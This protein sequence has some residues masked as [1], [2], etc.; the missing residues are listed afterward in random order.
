MVTPTAP[1]LSVCSREPIHIPGSVQ[2]H[3]VLLSIRPRDRVVLQVSANAAS[4]LGAAPDALLGNPLPPALEPALRELALP[5]LVDLPGGRCA[6]AARSSGNRLL[7]EVE[8]VRQTREEAAGTFAALQAALE[9][10][11]RA[12]GDELLQRV[13]EEFQRLTGFERVMVYRFDRDWHGE[14][15]A[16]C[17]DAGF[18]SFLGLHYPA[19]DI[20]AQARALYTRGWLRL[21]PDARATPSPLVPLLDPETAQPLDLSDAAL[22]SVSPVHIEYLHNM[23][24]LASMSVSILP[25]G[26]LWGLVSCHQMSAPR[27]VPRSIRAA[28][29]VLCRTLSGRI[30][31]AEQT[32]REAERAR[33]SAAQARILERTGSSG[34]HLERLAADEELLSLVGATGAA[35]STAGGRQIYSSG[36]TPPAAFVQELVAWLRAH[37]IERAFTTDALPERFPP[38]AAY[39]GIASGLLAAPIAAERGEWLLWFREERVRGVSWAGNPDKPVEPTAT[40]ISPR[41]SFDAWKQTVRGT[42]DPWPET[43]IDASVSMHN[44]LIEVAADRAHARLAAL[45]EVWP[46]ISPKRPPEAIATHVLRHLEA[47]CVCRAALEVGGIATGDTPRRYG[48]P[49]LPE[50]PPAPPDTTEPAIFDNGKHSV[51]Q[52]P[53]YRHGDVLGRLLLFREPGAS[54]APDDVEFVR[55]VAQRAAIALDNTRLFREMEESM[56]VRDEIFAMASHDLRNPLNLIGAA[57]QLLDR[58]TGDPEPVRKQATR[59]LGA[60]RKMNRTIDEIL[61]ATRIT[62][63]RRIPLQRST[64]DLAALVCEQVDETRAIAPKHRIEVHIPDAPVVGNWDA[65]RVRRVIENL[66]ANAIKYSPAGG[67]VAITLHVDEPKGEAVLSVR[68]EGIG[69]PAADLPR[70]FERFHRAANAASFPGTGVGLSGAARVVEAHCGTI[71]VASTEGAGSTFTVRLPLGG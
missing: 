52:V 36:E 32:A 70:I 45:V 1:D 8:P 20:P 13:A 44:A 50:L 39:A 12:S 27:H 54:W 28:C 23:G 51:L 30:A 47:V 49:D 38:A 24:V 61:D 71:E 48:A 25:R 55:A 33:Q 11:D 67:E 62:Q 18:D 34:N 17:V 5:V 29:E 41:K 6:A 19:S 56:S 7:V 46:E 4:L 53:L 9:R 43:A 42:S 60:T 26:R 66:L 3:G 63:G 2:P 22:R 59:I 35:V 31:V 65:A 57:A 10:L 68:D 16:E 21:I 14:V 64:F 37:K 15:V 69:I 40:R 58:R